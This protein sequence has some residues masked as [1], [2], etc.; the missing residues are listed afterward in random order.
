[1]FGEV[2]GRVDPRAA[3]AVGRRWARAKALLSVTWLCCAAE[4][5]VSACALVWTVVAGP[6]LP[7]LGSPKRGDLVGLAFVALLVALPMP[8]ASSMGR[9]AADGIDWRLKPDGW[10]LYGSVVGA[11]QAFGLALS[12]TYSALPLWA[13]TAVGVIGF[14][15]PAGA[16]F[17]ARRALL[18]EPLREI[19]GSEFVLVKGIRS[20]Q[21]GGE[22]SVKI[23]GDALRLS[24]RTA[25][26]RPAQQASTKDIALAEI[27]AIGV[28]PSKPEDGSWAVLADGRGSSPPQG[29]VVEIRTATDTQLLPADPEL[30]ELIRARAALHGRRPA[31]IEE[32]R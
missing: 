16:A 22:D 7:L 14:A 3:D 24:V 27:T 4:L 9:R 1:M 15:V 6:D 30:A 29:D 23:T 17:L 12:L 18:A 13:R 20:P 21:G 19:G 32:Q 26:G 5:V 31:G 11:A 25:A 10:F 8:L 28:R 2:P